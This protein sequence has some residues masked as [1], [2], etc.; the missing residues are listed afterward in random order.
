LFN[1]DIL[2][3]IDTDSNYYKIDKY[4][5]YLLKSIK[6]SFNEMSE[7]ERDKFIDNILTFINNIVQPAIDDTVKDIADM[8]NF[9]QIGFVGA[10]VEKIGVDGIWVAKKKYAI[11]KIYDEGTKY[12]KEPSLA[13][14]GLEYVRSSTPDYAKEV[15][16]KAIKIMLLGNEKELQDYMSK[17]KD[18]F[19]E[20]AKNYKEI[21]KISRITGV[22]SLDYEWKGDRL[23]KI[24]ANGSL[25]TAPMNSKAAIIYNQIIEEKGLTEKF[26]KIMDGNKIKI[27][28]LQ[29]DNPFGAEV[30]A[31]T[32]EEFL[33]EID[34]IKY[35]DIETLWE[36]TVMSGLEIILEKIN[37]SLKRNSIISDL[38]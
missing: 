21:G 14:T 16:G 7:N 8:F 37:W 13:V 24:K 2:L 25:Q 29:K 38:F 12:L 11:A 5:N 15:L 31:Y 32:D 18:K 1:K 17:A 19:Y 3:Y 4:V 22:N 35:I 36:K 23:C 9:Y 30:L 27:I 6:K 34:I 33:K 10:K 20:I 28:H 26:E